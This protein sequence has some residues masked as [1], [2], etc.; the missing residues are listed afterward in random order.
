[1]V[2]HERVRAVDQQHIDMLNR[3]VLQRVFDAGRAMRTAGLGN[4][5]AGNVGLI[6][7]REPL[8]KS[9]GN[10]GLHMGR[11]GI[12]I[13]TQTP[14]AVNNARKGEVLGQLD[15]VHQRRSPAAR[16]VAGADA[17]TRP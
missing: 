16:G 10:F 9:G 13:I 5:A 8:I 4:I 15:A 3:H 1:M 11:G 17:G 14:H 6:E 7:R 2:I 12:C